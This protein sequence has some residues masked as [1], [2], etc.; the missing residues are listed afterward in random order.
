M[1]AA[2]RGR[3]PIG[4]GSL[5]PFTTP[6]PGGNCAETSG[7]PPGSPHP[8]NAA[9]TITDVQTPNRMAN[10]IPTP[11]LTPGTPARSRLL[12]AALAAL[13]LLRLA[14]AALTPLSPDEA[15]YWT[16]SRA[17]APG[18]LDHPPM[19]AL[20][21]RLGTMIAGD[22]PLGVRL[23]APLAAAAGTLLLMDAARTLFPGTRTATRAAILLNATLI[24]GAG[25]VT[26][27]PD[28][29]LLLFW[30][31]ALAALARTALARTA[32][33]GPWWLAVGLASGLALDSKYTA[34]LLGLGIAF[35]LLTPAMRPH[36]RTPWPWLGGLLAALL[37]TPVIAWNATH[38]W[39]S[40][41]KQ[42]GRTADWHPA[43]AAQFLAELLAGQ[44]ALATPLLFVLFILATITAARRWRTP[45]WSLLAA[46][47]FPG[48]A[49]FLQHAIGDR[50]QP[51][52][53][54]I[55]YPAAALAAAAAPRRW[56]PG[57]A[58]LGAALTAAA[59]L[60]ATAQFP[61]PKF[62]DP[63]ARLAGWPVLAQAAAHTTPNPA[64]LASEE[65][66]QASLL[67]FAGPGPPILGADPRWTLVDLP[68]SA[69]TAPGLLLLSP[70]RQAPN[71]ALWTTAD[72]V[73]TLPRTRDGLELETYRL[74][75][76]T[77]RPGAPLARLPDPRRTPP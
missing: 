37:T 59:Y 46:L 24:L 12:W 35:W 18:Y 52:W 11:P 14:V 61:L 58:T 25:A 74:Y 40:F 32:A 8:A 56:W 20:W 50:V 33:A 30:T 60:Q 54:A 27:T 16:W 68:Q 47:I 49:L 48:T 71:P 7:G 69:P 42:G 62:L 73:A 38:G 29:P 34:A 51:N 15:Y 41:A 10:S 3:L 26:M 72:L 23:L 63:T 1:F 31:A 44:A 19:I 9:H 70:R 21:V 45:A 28:T 4:C 6:V 66:G 75:R 67:A 36:L 17:L 55:L 5:A 13:T 64:F 22:T 65:Y 39:A 77:P 57:A 53:P 43:R 76:V 2:P